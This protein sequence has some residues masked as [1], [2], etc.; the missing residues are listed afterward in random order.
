MGKFLII[1]SWSPNGPSPI[2]EKKFDIHKVAENGDINKLREIVVQGLDLD[3][4]TNK[5]KSAFHLAIKANKFE[6]VKF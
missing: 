6:S 4:K 3:R 1:P 5:Q 2:A